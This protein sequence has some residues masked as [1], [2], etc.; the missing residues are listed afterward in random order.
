MGRMPSRIIREEILTSGRVDQ[1]DPPSEVFYRR[2]LSKVDDH[3]LYDGRLAVIRAS[4]YPLRLDRVREADCSRWLA[5]CEKAGLIA[6]YNHDGQSYLQVM[7]TRWQARSAPKYPQPP[8]PANSCKQL[9]TVARLDVDVVVD[10]GVEK[11]K[12]RAAPLAIPESIPA[13]A[14]KDW[15]DYRNSRK[16]WTTKARALSLKTLIGLQAEGYDPRKVIEKS[17]EN[18]WTGLFPLKDGPKAAP[19]QQPSNNRPEETPLERKLA[20]LRHQQHIGAI[21]QDDFTQQAREA[22]EKLEGKT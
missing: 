13:E 16:G 15:H 10:V 8:T 1:L 22:R 7:N 17:I 6:L 19:Q 14:W 18:G 21:T 3:G 20:W 4:L 9:Q 12:G 11:T 5:A 2:L